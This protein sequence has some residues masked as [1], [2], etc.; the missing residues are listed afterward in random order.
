MAH[1]LPDNQRKVVVVH[2]LYSSKLLLTSSILRKLKERNKQRQ[3]D[4]NKQTNK[5]LYTLKCRLS[6]FLFALLLLLL[7]SQHKLRT[8]R[9]DKSSSNCNKRS[10]LLF[11]QYLRLQN[12]SPQF[13]RVSFVYSIWISHFKNE[14]CCGKTNHKRVFPQLFRV[15][16]NL[17]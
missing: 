4:R 14:K 15:L 6:C 7:F 3:T 5:A 11:P 17:Q 8:L 1:C 16:P 13:H 9:R 12:R 2:C 10:Y